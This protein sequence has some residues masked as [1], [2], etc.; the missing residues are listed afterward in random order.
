MTSLTGIGFIGTILVCLLCLGSC[1]YGEVLY[2]PVVVPEVELSRPEMCHHLYNNGQH[3][4]WASC[5][6]V[7]YDN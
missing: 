5:M 4:A 1:N 3:R 6:G 2:E 7:G